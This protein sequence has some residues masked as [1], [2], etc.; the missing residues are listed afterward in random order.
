MD[1]TVPHGI[2]F[3]PI[4]TIT[5]I[6]LPP[7]LFRYF[8]WL[9]FWETKTNPSLRRTDTIAFDEGSLGMHQLLRLEP[10]LMN[11]CDVR[12]GNILKV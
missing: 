5:V 4:G 7:M 2:S 9:P 12:C 8:A 10:G 1:L 11:L 6:I 3:C